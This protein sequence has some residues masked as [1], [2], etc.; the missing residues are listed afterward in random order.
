MS[1]ADVVDRYLQTLPGETR[2]LAHTEWGIS[3][4]AEHAG[5]YPLDVGVRIAEGILTAQAFALPANELG[6]PGNFPHCN[7]GPRFAGFASTT[8][9]QIWLHGDLPVAAV[10]DEASVDRLLGLLVE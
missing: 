9:A 6:N 1:A 5:G 2:R 4:D 10:T 8:P 3:I 7:R